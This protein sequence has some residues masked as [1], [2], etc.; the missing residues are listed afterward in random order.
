LA[1]CKASLLVNIAH[2]SKVN[3]LRAL[4]RPIRAVGVLDG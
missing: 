3:A 4:L 2:M 1:H